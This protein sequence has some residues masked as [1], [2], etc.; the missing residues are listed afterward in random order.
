MEM[1]RERTSGRGIEVGA[2]KEEERRKDKME[3]TCKS[4]VGGN[5]GDER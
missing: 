2:E 3:R 4:R 1:E 5:R